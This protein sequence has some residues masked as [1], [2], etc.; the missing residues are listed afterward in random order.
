LDAR[1]DADIEAEFDI[2]G[3]GLKDAV[4]EAIGSTALN[5]LHVDTHGQAKQKFDWNTMQNGIRWPDMPTGKVNEHL[6]VLLF[7]K[8]FTGNDFTTL[9]KNSHYG[10]L[11]HLHSMCPAFVPRQV[12]GV[13]VDNV[14]F[15]NADV[16]SFLI[17]QFKYL[18][19]SA[20]KAVAAND[21]A[22]YSHRL[23][24]MMHMLGDSYAPGHCPRGTVTKYGVDGRVTPAINTVPARLNTIGT[25]PL[26]SITER[27][28]TV[29]NFQG[30]G[31]QHGNDEHGARD[32]DP[33]DV[34]KG[35]TR[36]D[37]PVRTQLIRCAVSANYRLLKLFFPC[38]LAKGLG[39][40]C[41]VDLLSPL[42]EE[43]FRLAL[44]N[45]LAGGSDLEMADPKYP[46]DKFELMP[47]TW[48]NVIG[49]SKDSQM[50]SPKMP[51]PLPPNARRWTNIPHDTSLCAPIKARTGLLSLQ[52][53]PFTDFYNPDATGADRNAH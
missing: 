51:T 22:H 28:G 17:G 21:M 47:Y 9:V 42:L 41:S 5:Q 16:K 37:K 24:T 11:Q 36:K 45:E 8:D 31:T 30:Y 52:Q 53:V 43:I 15:T 2:L 40:T 25:D 34:I 35:A 33:K 14:F 4:H 10:C 39:P 32:H 27:C 12:D 3:N 19:S 20:V 13:Q 48:T 38:I 26:D 49:E 44:P 18:Y 23:G 46:K 6:P 29:I 7:T 1:L 50:V